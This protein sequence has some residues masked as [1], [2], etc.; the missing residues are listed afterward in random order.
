M[1]QPD[2]K[3]LRELG[4]TLRR[5]RKKQGVSM[6]TLGKAIGIGSHVRMRLESGHVRLSTFIAAADYL[7]LKVGLVPRAAWEKLPV[8]ICP[9]CNERPSQCGVAL[10]RKEKGCPYV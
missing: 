5:Y 4:Q 1:I 2:E 9:V 10:N 8:Q 6:N 7:G 3:L